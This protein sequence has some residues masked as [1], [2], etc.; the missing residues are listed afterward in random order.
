MHA[1]ADGMKVTLFSFKQ[2]VVRV[3]I[4]MKISYGYSQYYS[5]LI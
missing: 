2:V 3:N 5:V 4:I 1:A